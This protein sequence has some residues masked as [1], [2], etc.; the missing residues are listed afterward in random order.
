MNI[1]VSVRH[2]Y[3]EANDIA[4]VPANFEEDKIS[5]TIHVKGNFNFEY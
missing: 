2:V 1:K 3:R 5:D 4:D